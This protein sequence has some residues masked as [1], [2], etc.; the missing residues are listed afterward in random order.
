MRQQLKFATIGAMLAFVSACAA[1]PKTPP[2]TASD[3][4]R[5]SL[6]LIIQLIPI[7]FAP[8]EGVDDPG[9]KFDTDAT[10]ERIMEQNGKLRAACPP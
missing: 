2:A 8:A 5:T 7:A 3:T 6:C 10:A 1:Q 4:S 9:N